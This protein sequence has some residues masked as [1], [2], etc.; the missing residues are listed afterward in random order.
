MERNFSGLGVA[1]RAPKPGECI[2]FADPRVTGLDGDVFWHAEDYRRLVC[3][4]V[5]NIADRG[6]ASEFCLGKV[7][8][9]KTLLKTISGDQFIILRALRSVVQIHCVGEDI[10]TDPFAIEVIVDGF[11][12]VESAHKVI[13]RAADLC[14]NHP[15]RKASDPWTVEA[16]RHRDALVAFDLKQRGRN[17]QEVA[18]F[19]D[20]EERVDEEWN[21]PNRTLK[22]RTIRSVKR[23]IR[24]VGGDYRTLLK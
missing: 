15:E 24:M 16:L 21:N 10:R 12:E 11:P 1:F 4:N 22:N 6:F 23:G 3:A 8:C 18:R 19:L 5:R 2:C 14:R 13:R 20:G 7:R 9:K 17:Y